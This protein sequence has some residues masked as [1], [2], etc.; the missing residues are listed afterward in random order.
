MGWS[1]NEVSSGVYL[2]SESGKEDILTDFWN[3]SRNSC[4][5]VFS[6]RV[7]LPCIVATAARTGAKACP[8]PFS[9]DAIVGC[10]RLK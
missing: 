7:T 6:D 4:A 10:G 3:F 1:Q 5:W 9:L 8:A 2:K